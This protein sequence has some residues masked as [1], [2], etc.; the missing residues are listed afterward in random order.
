MKKTKKIDKSEE[1]CE[2][3]CSYLNIGLIK[4]AIIAFVLMVAKLWNSILVLE[5]YW[6]L[7][8][9]IAAAIKPIIHGHCCK[10]RD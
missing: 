6:Y 8:I 7:I 9:A 3:C 5:W 4:I 10:S 2:Y 1:S